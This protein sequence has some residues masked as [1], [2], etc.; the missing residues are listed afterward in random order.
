MANIFDLSKNYLNR[1]FE[2]NLNR[3]LRKMISFS[4]RLFYVRFTPL[5]SLRCATSS[6]RDRYVL[7]K[8]HPANGD[9]G[10][11]YRLHGPSLQ[12]PR[13]FAPFAALHSLRKVFRKASVSWYLLYCIITAKIL[14]L[15]KNF[16]IDFWRWFEQNIAVKQLEWTVIDQWLFET[17]RPR[18]WHSL[19]CNA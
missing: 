1:F 7:R 15:S 8:D 3:L 9:P 5:Q 6:A 4:E 18:T 14:D 13:P 2:S 17:L 19:H 11:R 10:L 16:G 12:T